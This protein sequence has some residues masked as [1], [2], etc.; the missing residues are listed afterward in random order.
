MIGFGYAHEEGHR[1]R[2]TWR[3]GELFRGEEGE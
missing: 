1:L 3:G 2:V